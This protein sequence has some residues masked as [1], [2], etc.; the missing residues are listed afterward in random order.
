[1]VTLIA[2]G[3]RYDVYD[4]TVRIADALSPADALALVA[5]TTTTTTI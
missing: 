3:G 5:T 2:A 4:G 1:M